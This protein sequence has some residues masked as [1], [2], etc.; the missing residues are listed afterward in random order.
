MCPPY[1]QTFSSSTERTWRV[2]EVEQ[3]RAVGALVEVHHGR[4]LRLDSDAAL[5]FHLRE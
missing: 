3:V 5:S 4:R 1:K 2:D